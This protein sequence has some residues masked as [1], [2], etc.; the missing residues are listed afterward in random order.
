MFNGSI[1]YIRTVLNLLLL[2]IGFLPLIFGARLLVDGASSV[3]TRF[4][5]PNI[6][7]GLTIVAF[8]TSAPELVVNLIA[9]INQNSSLVLGNVLGSNIFNILG[10]IGIAALIY[11]L[12]VKS[13]TTWIEIPLSFLAAVVLLVIAH[14]Q[15]IDGTPFNSIVRTDGIVL[16]LFFS[17]FIAYSFHSISSDSTP[18]KVEV[19]KFSTLHS[20]LY[21]LIGLGLLIVG[22]RVIVQSAVRFAQRIGLPER[23][24]ALT[25]VSIGTS[26][27]ELATSAVAA[28]KKNVDIAIGNIVG[29][30]IFNVF[31]ILGLSAVVYPVKVT[32]SSALD[33]LVH[34]GTAVLLFAVIFI[35]KGRKVDRWEGAIFIGLYIAYITVLLTV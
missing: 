21:I 14:K 31:F 16:L 3:A 24:I 7:I 30:N 12:Q 32:T 33:L 6:V 1:W 22:G 9:A 29:S 26:L 17:I 19:H 10:I 34:T 2:I 11:P 15:L 20:V 25:I 27:P 13:R 23:I 8:G 35:G 4:N 18:E 5:V 28:F